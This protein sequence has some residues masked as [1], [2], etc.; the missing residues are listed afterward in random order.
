MSFGLQGLQNKTR[1]ILRH[2][3]GDH[4]SVRD[5]LKMQF[6]EEKI[7][8]FHARLSSYKSTLAIAL[9]FSELQ[10]AFSLLKSI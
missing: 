1:H 8:A 4:V 10:E 3:T 5:R 6:Q 2:S 9:E 7:A